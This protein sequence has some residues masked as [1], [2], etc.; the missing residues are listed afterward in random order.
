[1]TIRKRRRRA[2]IAADIR[3]ALSRPSTSLHRPARSC[4]AHD[5]VFAK[6]CW[7]EVGYLRGELNDRTGRRRSD[8]ACSVHRGGTRSGPAGSRCPTC[9]SGKGTPATRH[10]S[11]PP[12]CKRCR[13]ATPSPGGIAWNAQTSSWDVR[14]RI[15]LRVACGTRVGHS[16]SRFASWSTSA[17]RTRIQKLD[18]RL[19]RAR[20]ELAKILV[21]TRASPRDIA[22]HAAP[23]A[24]WL[25][26]AGGLAVG[27]R[28][29]GP[30][31]AQPQPE[32]S[33]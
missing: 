32:A 8:A 6:R 5:R 16:K 1:M 20:A 12:R 14:G 22:A 30:A 18:R 23:A 4:E 25:R 7:S 11:S 3:S 9:T 19:G 2:G 15:K 28:R 29:A 26:R 21:A 24:A 31:I 27:D 33:R 13:S 10:A 17:T